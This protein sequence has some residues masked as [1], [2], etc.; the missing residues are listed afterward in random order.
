MTS[1]DTLNAEKIAEAVLLY[2]FT[3]AFPASLLGKALFTS[4]LL[5]RA[6]CEEEE[7]MVGQEK[8]V[9]LDALTNI[10]CSLRKSKDGDKA[11]SVPNIY[12]F[13]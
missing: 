8:P 6:C 10:Y 13:F 2:V 12:I 5:V 4:F 7:K 1:I 3:I 11:E 9:V